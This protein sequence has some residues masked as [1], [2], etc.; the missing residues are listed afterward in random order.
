MRGPIVPLT[1]VP[2]PYKSGMEFDPEPL[3]EPS[4]ATQKEKEKKI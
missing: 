4:N 3:V 2:V 1:R